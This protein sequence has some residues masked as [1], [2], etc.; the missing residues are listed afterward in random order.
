VEEPV[1][2]LPS[3]PDPAL[4]VDG[5]MVLRRFCCPGCRTQMATEIARAEEAIFPEM[6]LIA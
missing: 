3:A 6:R 1:T 4:F 2:A 5:G